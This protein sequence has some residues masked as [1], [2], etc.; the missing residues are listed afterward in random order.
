MC[1]LTTIVSI[2]QAGETLYQLFDKVCVINEGRMAYFGPAD[3]ARQY[4]IDMGYQPANRQTTSDFLVAVTDPIGRI[5][6]PGVGGQPRSAGEFAEYFKR[7]N[8]AKVGREDMRTYRE[9]CVG[10]RKRR[11]SYRKSA[12]AEHAHNTRNT[13]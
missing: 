3:R 6:R 7:S 12:L 9:E 8:I 5:P 1:R 13:S 2:Y 10:S 11:D 4:F